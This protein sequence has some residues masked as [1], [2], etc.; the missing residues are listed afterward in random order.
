MYTRVVR[1]TDVD[2][3]RLREV[4][5]RVAQRERPP[6]G[7]PATGV[8]FLVDDAQRTAVVLQH[9][10]SAEDMAK[11]HEVMGAM[12]AAGTP[13]SRVSVDLCEVKVTLGAPA[14]A[15]P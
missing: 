14:G 1:F 9:F 6:E 4:L 8:S 2:P 7:V 11:G 10:A 12:D 13:G 3:E 15:A 5:A